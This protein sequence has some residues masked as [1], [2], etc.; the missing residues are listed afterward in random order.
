MDLAATADMEA[1]S[2]TVEQALGQ[3]DP[4]SASTINFSVLFSEPV[5]GFATGDVT[6]GGSAGATTATVSGSGAA[7]NVA[8][9]GM[10]ADGTVIADIPAAVAIDAAGNS[11]L[12][13]TSADNTVTY[14]T[15]PPT[16]TIEQALGQA[17]PAGASPISFSVLFS[18]PVTGF[19]T[20]DVTIGGTAGA[21]TATVSGSGAAYNVAIS[22][23]TADGTV[24]V[25]D[26]PAAVAIDAAGNSNLASTSADNTVTYDDITPPTVTIEQAL[27]QADPT[28]SSP[29][30]FSV[31]FSEPVNGFATGDV[32]LSGTAGATTATV[33]GTGATYNVAVSGMTADGTVIVD[34]IPAGV[35][36]DGGSNP[37]LV[38]T[39]I[40]N[41]VTYDDITPPTVTIEQALGQAD[42]T[43]ADPINFSVLFSE[44]VTGFATGDVTA[45]GTAGATMATVSG[46]GTTYNVA[47][48][49]MTAD[50]TVIADIPAG[51]AIDGGSNSNL[52]STSIDN[53]VTTDTT[54]PTVTIEQALGQADPTNADPINFSALFSEPVTGFAT[55]DVTAS[56]TAGATMATVSGTGSGT[57]YNLAVSGMT[58]D[59]TV[60][61]GIP[62][63]MAIDAAS[64]SNL[65]STSAD[66]T[67]SYD[68]PDTTPPMATTGSSGSWSDP[69]IWSTGAV[70]GAGDSVRISQGTTVTYDLLSDVVLGELYVEGTLRFSRTTDT[71]MKISDNILVTSGGFFDIGTA[72]Q[73]IPNGVKS[74]LIF[75]LPQGYAFTGGAAMEPRDKGVW[76]MNGSRWEV[77]GTPLLRPWS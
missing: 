9:S 7:Y 74:E 30:S 26:I 14:D 11:N 28:S 52:V 45:S 67:V 3:A 72:Q 73:P 1:P 10:T 36:I 70:P 38:S 33:S 15:T 17:D 56:G 13:S 77:H 58:A 62:A 16:V 31:L 54:P 20:G 12:A 25:D 37:N 21:T 76:V 61:A 32:T 42:P 57:T 6:I 23:M 59:G 71:R 24:I 4:T 46:S 29:I 63:G 65:A 64:N 49:G 40:D 22:G 44:P 19:A 60:I 69:T 53:T 66:N 39:S 50:G 34:D 41:T 5:T 2:A 55:G 68:F 43:N 18:E 75:V 8:N 47:I 27:G 48:S 51:V 35:A